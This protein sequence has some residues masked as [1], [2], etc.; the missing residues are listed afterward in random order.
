MK[1]KKK[2]ARKGLGLIPT[3]KKPKRVKRGLGLIPTEKTKKVR[4]PG[5]NFPM[6]GI[7]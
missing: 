3:E 4:K 7:K 1:S 5:F 6:K 2:T